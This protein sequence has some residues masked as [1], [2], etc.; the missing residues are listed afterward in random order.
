MT[1]IKKTII[2]LK[3]K[4]MKSTKLSDNFYEEIDAH[5]YERLSHPHFDNYK[6]IDTKHAN[7][8]SANL[9]GKTNFDSFD[10]ETENAKSV[11][12]SPGAKHKQNSSKFLQ[13]FKN[14]KSNRK[15]FSIF[16]GIMLAVVLVVILAIVFI[17]LGVA[18]MCRKK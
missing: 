11:V 18:S 12:N 7:A 1:D 5:L 2:Q 15:K 10:Q 13:F 9:N 4:K 16:L 17:V 8:K 6:E 14:L 3:I